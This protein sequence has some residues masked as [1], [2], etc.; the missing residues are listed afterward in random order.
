MSR[1]VTLGGGGKKTLNF[2]KLEDDG[3]SMGGLLAGGDENA[4]RKSMRGTK[5]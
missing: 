4:S 5:A 3:E 2:G 1:A